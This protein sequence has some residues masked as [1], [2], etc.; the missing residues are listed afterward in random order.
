MSESNADKPRVL[1]RTGGKLQP[2]MKPIVLEYKGRNKKKSETKPEADKEKYTEGLE[3][4]QV[5][6]GNMIH[7]AQKAAKAA[8]KGLDTY[9]HERQKSAKAKTDGAIEDFFNNSAKAV[10]ASLKEASDIPIDVVESINTESY[11]K[12]L[13]KNLKRTSKFMRLFRI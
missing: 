2:E 1:R 13:R 5:M 8:S 11:R 10:S 4:V 3:D 6:E 7:I 9:E 12:R